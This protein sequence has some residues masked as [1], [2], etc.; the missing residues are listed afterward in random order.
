MSFKNLKLGAKLVIGFGTLILISAILGIIAVFNM[1]TIS[2][3]ADV[4]ATEY[5]PEVKIAT[6]LRGASNRAMYAMRGYGLTEEER[7]YK[8]AVKELEMLKAA[9]EEGKELDEV[10]VRLTKLSE[11]LEVAEKAM[12]TYLALVEET[13]EVNEKLAESRKEMDESATK[14]MGNCNTYLRSQNQAMNREIRSGNTSLT[15][16][17]KITLINNIIDVGNEIRV[18]NFKAQAQRN[19]KILQSALDEFPEV[20]KYMAEIRRYTKV[21][22]DIVALNVIDEEASHY[23]LA[24]E[25]YLE[26]WRI[27]EDLAQKRDEAGKTLIKAC[28]ETT[29]AG[30]KGTQNIANNTIEILKSSSSVMIYGLVLALIIGLLFAIFLTRAIS[31]PVNKGVE[32]AKKLANGDLTATIDVDQKDEIGQ[33][34]TAL[35]DMALKLRT[36]VQDIIGGANN[37]ASASQQMASTSQ[38]ISQGANEQASSVEEVSSTIEEITANISQNTDNAQLTE[39][40]SIEANTGMQTVAEKAQASVNANQVIADKITVI[41]DIAFQ[42]NILALNAAVEAARAGESGKGFAVVAA[43]VRKLAEHS[44]AAAE[45]I[46]SLSQ[47]S[48]DMAQTAGSVMMDTI[49][50][51][52]KTTNLVQEISSASL[53]QANGTQQINRAVQQLNIVTQQNAASSEELASGA[54]ELAGQAEQLK[55]IIKFLKVDN[56]ARNLSSMISQKQEQ[57]LNSPT[58]TQKTTL[59]TTENKA[60][61]DLDMNT[62]DADFKEY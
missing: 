49:P 45:E 60:V 36:V 43:E 56:Q 50:K 30:L 4:L 37:I 2:V 12:N 47:T 9:I 53:E 33:L 15:R 46:V 27:R 48:L 51:I 21:D 23:Q 41:N 26:N 20:D 13:V 18:N 61:V 35:T 22:A 3:E 5:V 29:E 62:S 39:N 19:P 25:T 54:E 32:F 7:F 40:V 42:T 38:M 34:A 58:P 31:G 16:L 57:P 59:E 28:A 1:N 10:A 14:Y 52:E 11:E 44:K 8:D 6:D 24:M 55:E 17:Q